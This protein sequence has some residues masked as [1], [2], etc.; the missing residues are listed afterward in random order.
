MR[1]QQL[2]LLYVWVCPLLISQRKHSSSETGHASTF[3]WKVRGKWHRYVHYMI[4]DGCGARV[5][6]VHPFHL[7]YYGSLSNSHS[8][9][10]QWLDQLFLKDSTQHMPLPL[11]TQDWNRSSFWNKFFSSVQ[12]MMDKVQNVVT[13]Q[14]LVGHHSTKLIRSVSH[15]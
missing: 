1:G 10:L 15:N 6:N 13:L 8:E 3:S 14:G 11:F 9:S 5:V 2:S 7:F 4:K 12:Q